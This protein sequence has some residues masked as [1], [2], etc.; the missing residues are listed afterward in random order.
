MDVY[1]Q[2]KKAFR[3][4]KEKFTE[5]KARLILIGE[6]L[7]ETIKVESINSLEMFF[8]GYYLK[9]VQNE[10]IIKKYQLK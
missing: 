8:L 10:E 9:T 2:Y 1:F 6:G 7:S 5:T 4:L 3:I